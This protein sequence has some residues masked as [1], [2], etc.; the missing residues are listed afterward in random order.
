[1][2]KVLCLL[3][4]LVVVADASYSRNGLIAFSKGCQKCCIRDYPKS[5]QAK[6]KCW[7]RNKMSAC[8]RSHNLDPCTAATTDSDGVAYGY[9]GKV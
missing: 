7:C 1:M 9:C 2:F 4:V 5:E 8:A 6:C 3:F